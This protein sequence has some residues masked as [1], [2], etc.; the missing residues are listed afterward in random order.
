[1]G[2]NIR[3]KTVANSL[4]SSG[5]YSGTYEL[6]DALKIQRISIVDHKGNVLAHP[7]P[8]WMASA[9][10]MAKIS[11][12]CRIMNGETGIERFYSPALR[13]DMI[14]GLPSVSGPGWGV[15]IP[16]PVA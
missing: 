14:A 6:L 5:I 10:N 9:R 1:V 13:G 4:D 7:V 8:S 12:V 11:A 16:Q 15:M 2:F 3:I